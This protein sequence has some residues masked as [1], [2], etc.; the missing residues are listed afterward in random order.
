ERVILDGKGA[1]YPAETDLT[2]SQTLYDSGARRAELNRQ[3]SRVD[4]A[5]FRVLERSEFI[6]LAVVQDYLEYMLQASIVTEAKKNL[7]FHQSILGDIKQGIAGG[8]LN[9]AD[10]QQAEE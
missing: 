2:I 1:L 8:A 10:R 4:G 9:D 5:S 6:G 7:A 3:A